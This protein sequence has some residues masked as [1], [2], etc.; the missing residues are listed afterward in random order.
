MIEDFRGRDRKEIYRR[1][2]DRGRLMPDGLRLHHSWISAD[3]GRC[4]ILMEADDVTLLQRWVIE[5]SDLVDFEIVP[6][7]TNKDMVDGLSGH[8]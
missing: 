2:R 7:A 5:W 3:M 4:F 8:L 6:V 1:F